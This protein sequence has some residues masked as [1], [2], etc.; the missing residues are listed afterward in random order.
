[1]TQDARF[2]LPLSLR[3][4][5]QVDPSPVAGELADLLDDEP[6]APA[7]APK[8]VRGGVATG[9]RAAFAALSLAALGGT[10]AHAASPSLAGR[11][12]MAPADSR[13][14]EAVTGRAPEAATLIVTRDNGDRLAY[15]LIETGRGVR[16]VRAAY[17]V[18]LDGAPSRSSNDG[19]RLSVTARRDAAG[20]V[21]ISAPPVGGLRALIRVHRTGRDT[22]VLEHLVEGAADGPAAAAGAVELERISLV[23]DLPAATTAE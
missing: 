21:V 19:V 7:A 17:D 4:A 13:F 11:W 1:M 22:A 16:P 2:G 8:P 5:L 3:E 6:A 15:Q 14:A 20:D 18:S 23:R 12:R 10:A 9:W